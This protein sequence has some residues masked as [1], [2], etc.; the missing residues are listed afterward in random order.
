[1]TWIRTGASLMAH[2]WRGDEDWAKKVMWTG[3]ALSLLTYAQIKK[4]KP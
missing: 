4:L 2:I 3:I 1:M